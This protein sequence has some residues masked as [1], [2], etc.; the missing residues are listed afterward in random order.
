MTSATEFSPIRP[1]RAS[2]DMIAQIREAIVSGRFQPGD[3]LPTQRSMARQ[4]GVS[5]VTVRDAL[6]ALESTGLVQVRLGGRGGP[7]VAHPDV[8]LLTQSL[9]THMQLTGTTFLE[10]AEARLA[11]E[12]TAARLAAERATEADL[13]QMRAALARAGRPSEGTA[14]TSLDFHTALVQAAHNQAL[15][16]MFTATRALIQEAFDEL[17][18][19]QPDMAVS[20]RKAHRELLEAIREHEG[21][22]A[23]A[24]MRSHLYEFAER[25]ER[26]ATQAR[27]GRAR[28]VSA[29]RAR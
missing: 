22:R 1:V 4:F 25:A 2:S 12:T 16:T 3:R 6:R 5:R 19:R 21:D 29:G 9:A 11:L 28:K 23:V 18:R 26:A 10:L 24:I 15:T 14:A 20:A 7:Y 13:E 17:H 8:S 27:G